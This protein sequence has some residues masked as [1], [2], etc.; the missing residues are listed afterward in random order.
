MFQRP[1]TFAR[2]K[3]YSWPNADNEVSHA[4]VSSLAD[5][6]R[7]RHATGGG[8]ARC[9]TRPNNGSEGDNSECSADSVYFCLQLFRQ[10]TMGKK[11]SPSTFLNF[12]TFDLQITWNLTPPF[13]PLFKPKLI[14]DMKNNTTNDMPRETRDILSC[15]CFFSTLYVDCVNHYVIMKTEIRAARALA[16]RLLGLVT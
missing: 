13:S 7:S 15:E 12:F 2:A 4:S 3:K 10:H 16:W 11:S 1:R 5:F 9:V 14:K 8:R 6:V